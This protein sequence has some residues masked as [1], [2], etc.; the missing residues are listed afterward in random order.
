MLVVDLPPGT[1]DPQLT[2]AQTVR[3]DGVVVVTT[4]SD[5]ALADVRRGLLMFR[6]VGVPVLGIVENMS[7]F[8]CP[9]CDQAYGI[10]GSGGGARTAQ[11]LEVPFLGEIPIDIRICRGSDQ[12]KPIVVAAPESSA[13]QAFSDLAERTLTS[14]QARQAERRVN[15]AP[16]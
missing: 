10:F 15:P 1:G 11:A 5:L 4:P 13:A 12:G 8:V 2:L 9:R 6:G 14:V 3:I 7:Y 16:P